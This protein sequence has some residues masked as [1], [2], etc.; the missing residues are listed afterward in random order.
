MTAIHKKYTPFT[1]LLVILFLLIF[2]H[3][4]G[5]PML[6]YPA[7]GL[8]LLWGYGKLTGR[9]LS[10]FGFRWRDC[11]IKSFLIGCLTGVAYAAL[12]YWVIGP[13]LLRITGLPPANLK[14]FYGIRENITQ[15]IMLMAIAWLWVI[16]YEE[17]VFR[18]YMFTVLR[19]WFNSFWFAAIINSVLFAGYHWQEG[20]SAMITI[21][22]FS[23]IAVTIYKYSKFN[24]W[25]VIFFHA[26]YDTVMLTL[27]RM[28]Y[29]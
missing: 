15:Y 6:L 25:Y 4:S 23:L 5:V 17:I 21:F 24:L 29:M 10:S 14:D 12:L 13:L 8:L 26:A 9:T 7:L 16:P 20:W 18:G 2:P 3:V 11:T 19:K 22:I 1:D 28:G 27:I